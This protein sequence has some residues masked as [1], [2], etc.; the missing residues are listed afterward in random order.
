MGC[1]EGDMVELG[2]KNCF[3]HLFPLTAATAL[4]QAL[5]ACPFLCSVMSVILTSISGMGFVLS[6]EHPETEFNFLV[7]LVT[8]EHFFQ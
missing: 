1:E 6:W 5:T 8:P 2:I 7:I 4:S 3:Q